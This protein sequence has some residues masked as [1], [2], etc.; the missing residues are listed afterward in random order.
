LIEADSFALA[1]IEEG[2]SEP[3]GRCAT[4]TTRP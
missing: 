2:L 4:G 1:R 3:E